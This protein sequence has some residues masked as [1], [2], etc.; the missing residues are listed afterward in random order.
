LPVLVK[1]NA[2][3]SLGWPHYERNC[4]FDPRRPADEM[5]IVRVVSLR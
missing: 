5:R 2:C 3:S 4:Q 1:G